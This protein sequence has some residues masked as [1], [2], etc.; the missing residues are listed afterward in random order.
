M[1]KLER[2]ADMEPI[3]IRTLAVGDAEGD[4]HLIAPSDA[5]VDLVEVRKAFGRALRV[6]VPVL[7]TSEVLRGAYRNQPMLVDESLLNAATLSFS[8]TRSGACETLTQH[9]FSARVSGATV[10]HFCVPLAAERADTP[11][12]RDGAQTQSNLTRF[13]ALRL[14]RR[15]NEIPYIPP[16]PDAVVSIMA[17]RANPSYDVTELTRIIESDP[18]LSSRILGWANSSFCAADAT[19]TSIPDAIVRVLGPGTALR[20]ALTVTMSQ[21][22]RMPDEHVCGASPIWLEAM[23]SAATM[24]ALAN[25][26]AEPARPSPELAYAAGLFSNFG[27]LVLGHVFPPLYETVCLLQDAN[28]HLPH[29]YVDQHCIGAPREMLASELLEQWNLP[30]EIC[31]AVRFQ[32]M[33]DYRGEH[34]DYVRLLALTRRLLAADGITDEP[35]TDIEPNLLRDLALPPEAIENVRQS[36]AQ[37]TG[38]LDSNKVAAG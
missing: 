30:V 25:L 29:T 31:T 34:A 17:L 19:I 21:P 33:R 14:R 37:S 38:T 2:S 26:T 8:D 1:T 16:L 18:S 27:T 11:V 6:T 15:L 9:E 4:L 12:S 20:L 22:I 3:A 10:H 7:A 36:I 24:E 28:R 13:S 32:Q 23:L 35:C 5:L